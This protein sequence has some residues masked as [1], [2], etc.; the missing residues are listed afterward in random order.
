MLKWVLR[1]PPGPRRRPHDLA[2]LRARRPLRTALRASESTSRLAQLAQRSAD[3]T[4]RTG[5]A[6]PRPPRARAAVGVVRALLATGPGPGREDLHDLDP[7]SLALVGELAPLA[8]PAL[9]LITSARRRRP[10][11]PAAARTLRNA[12]RHPVGAAAHLAPFT[13][14]RREL[15][16]AHHGSTPSPG[17]GP[18]VLHRTAANPFWLHRTA[19]RTRHGRRTRTAPLPTHVVGLLSSPL[20]GEPARVGHVARAA[21]LLGEAVESD[22]LFHVCGGDV[23]PALRRLLDLACW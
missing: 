15:V 13:A 19:R 22:V 9:L 18:R 20:A 5:E 6:R 10:V 3:G 2:R 21:A 1:E 17:G 16:E 4:R 7:A 12:R 14:G 23:E 8:P 11:A